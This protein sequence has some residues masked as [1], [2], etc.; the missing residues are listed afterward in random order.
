MSQRGRRNL[1]LAGGAASLAAAGLWG[2]AE[3]RS[4]FVAY[5]FAFVFWSA[6]PLGRR[7]S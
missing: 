4:F 3:P 7:R 1:L 5:L 6:L 2:L